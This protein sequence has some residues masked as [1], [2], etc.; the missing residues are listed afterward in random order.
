MYDLIIVGSGPAGLAAGIYAARFK[1]NTLIIG[2]KPGGSAADASKIDNYPG[3]PGL[4]GS[5]IMDK[6]R[7][8]LDIFKIPIKM[9]TAQKITKSKIG[10]QV[11]TDKNSY[12]AKSIIIAAGTERKRLSIP[13]EQEFMGKGVAFCATCDAFFFKNKAVVVVGGGDAAATSA[14]Q[15]TEF[16][17]IVYLILRGE[18]LSAAPINIDRVNKNKKIVL[19]PNNNINKINGTN[20]V[21][22]IVLDK[23]FDD[24]NELKTD[25]VFI[26]IGTTP[27]TD[28]IKE[29]KV[30][31]DDRGYIKVDKTQET[32][33]KG[34]FAAGDCTTGSNKFQQII[35]AS[36]EGAIASSCVYRYLRENKK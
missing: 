27:L 22:S 31:K 33:I 11:I 21:E 7:K 14:I 29:L 9:E 15:L 24:S 36:A 12:K 6:F 4:A 17:K 16:A 34:V 5:E 3:L 28:L 19:I 13:G 1:I 25:G 10:F 8:H 32:N 2:F 30:E 20:F 26:E 23:V 18:K 35:T